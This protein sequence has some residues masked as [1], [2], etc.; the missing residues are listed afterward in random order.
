MR[1]AVLTF[2]DGEPY[3][4]M[5]A[6]HVAHKDYN[7]QNYYIRNY[8]IRLEIYRVKIDVVLVLTSNGHV[9]VSKIIVFS[10]HDV[11]RL[12]ICHRSFQY[13][14]SCDQLL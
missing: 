8:Y 13:G 2:L 14:I 9:F 12:R 11:C 6:L 5:Y 7:D 10:I 3:I 4:G 1:H